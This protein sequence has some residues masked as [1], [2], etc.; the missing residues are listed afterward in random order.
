MESDVTKSRRRAT[1]TAGTAVALVVSLIGGT[2]SL[3]FSGGTQQRKTALKPLEPPISAPAIE[4]EPL[5]STGG[6][7]DLSMFGLGD[8]SVSSMTDT[9]G[10]V[11][12]SGFTP[13]ASS[14]LPPL[15][16]FQLPATST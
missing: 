5:P 15:P 16:S 7:T 3:L 2:L 6:Q 8:S 4:P 13:S 12:Q 11:A 14:A 10:G 1:V 9:S